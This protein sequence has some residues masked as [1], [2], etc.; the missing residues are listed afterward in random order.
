MNSKLKHEW[1]MNTMIELKKITNCK[2]EVTLKYS[3]ND[4]E[5]DD[6]ETSNVNKMLS[7]LSTVLLSNRKRIL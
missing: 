7:L 4:E 2:M 6:D 1:K 3:K 5:I